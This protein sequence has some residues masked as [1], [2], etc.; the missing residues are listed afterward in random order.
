MN[1]NEKKQNKDKIEFYV[2]GIMEWKWNKKQLELNKFEV[3]I[4]IMC[5]KKN[6]NFD[7]WN[8]K[9]VW[10]LLLGFSIMKPIFTYI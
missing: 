8:S 6:L 5:L 7:E 10:M 3:K 2:I 9:L 1:K 4:L